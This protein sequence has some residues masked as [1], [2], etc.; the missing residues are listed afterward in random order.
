MPLRIGSASLRTPV[1]LGTAATHNSRGE[2]DDRRNGHEHALY[3]IDLPSR[4]ALQTLGRSQL[5][6][7]TKCMERTRN[8]LP[9]P[10]IAWPFEIETYA[11]RIC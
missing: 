5:R 9:C 10:H 7:T 4:M 11:G 6:S 1:P 8:S 3:I 2:Q